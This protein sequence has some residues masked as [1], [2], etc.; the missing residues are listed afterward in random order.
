MKQ[1]NEA[2]FSLAVPTI[3]PDILVWMELFEL[4]SRAAFK[5]H[6]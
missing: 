2:F 6:S 5:N 3:F 1:Q 4:K